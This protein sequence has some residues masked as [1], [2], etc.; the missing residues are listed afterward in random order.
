MQ[1]H[2]LASAR[3]AVGRAL[4]DSRALLAP[5]RNRIQAV[6]ADPCLCRH[7]G[8]AEA[9]AGQGTTRVITLLKFG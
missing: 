1:R 6:E 4:A 3:G 2:L 7:T 5:W 9:V 8:I